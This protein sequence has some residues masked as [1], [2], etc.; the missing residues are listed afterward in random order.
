MVH[1]PFVIAR[2]PDVFRR[3]KQSSFGP[4]GGLIL[5]ELDCRVADFASLRLLLAMTTTVVS[6]FVSIRSSRHPE[7]GSG[8]L[9]SPSLVVRVGRWMLKRV[10]HDE[11]CARSAG[12]SQ[13]KV[14]HRHGDLRI[15][16]GFCSLNLESHTFQKLCLRSMSDSG[17]LEE[18]LT[19]DQVRGDDGGKGN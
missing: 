4:R 2:T 16:Y 15:K 6:R 1:I 17:R 8:S 13:S 14:T 9:L 10:Q 12:K 5:Q 3:T 18:S 19:P 7:L 11:E